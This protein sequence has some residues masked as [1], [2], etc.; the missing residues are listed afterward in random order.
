M[1]KE[2]PKQIQDYLFSDNKPFIE[3]GIKYIKDNNLNLKEFIEEFNK[4]RFPLFNYDKKGQL[5]SFTTSTS[6]SNSFR[7]LLN[8]FN[9]IVV[10]KNEDYYALKLADEINNA[11]IWG[12]KAKVINI[13]N[14]DL[15]QQ[16]TK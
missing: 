14:G 2:L 5:L 7:L 8:D 9:D 1:I 16:I 12:V 3:L 4:E 10:L 15:I 11:G 13:E 6:C